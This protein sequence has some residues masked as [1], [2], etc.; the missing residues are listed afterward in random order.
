MKTPTVCVAALVLFAACSASPIFAQAP[1]ATPASPKDAR[2]GNPNAVRNLTVEAPVRVIACSADGTLV[3]VSDG[4][5]L[6]ATKQVSSP[7]LA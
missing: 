7:S 1:A 6:C 3:A 2:R 4:V 5:R